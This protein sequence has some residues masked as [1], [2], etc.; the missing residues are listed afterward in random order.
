MPAFLIDK[1]MVVWYTKSSEKVVLL[2]DANMQIAKNSIGFES[3]VYE[4]VCS[5]LNRF[6]G[7]II[8]FWVYWMTERCLGCLKR[9]PLIW[10]KIL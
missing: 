9:L 8:Y 3:A 5:F 6:G 1:Q 7:D 4:T 2:F 10:L